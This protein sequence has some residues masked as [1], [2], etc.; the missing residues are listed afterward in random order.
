MPKLFVIWGCSGHAKVLTSI[1]NTQGGR[2]LAYFDNC[3]INS[4]N[5]EIPIYFGEAGF[6]TWINEQK[7]L[8][9]VKGL[10]AIGGR[11]GSD[12]VNI[13]NI[14]RSAGLNLEPLI[15]PTAFVCNTAKLGEGSQVLAQ[16]IVA[17]DS[18]LGDVCIINH[19]ASVDH[20]C[21]LGSGVHLAPGATI[22]GC[23]T[24]G[25]NVL[26]GAGAVIL[27]RLTIGSNSI[28]GAGAVVTKNVASGEVVMGNP[29]H[30]YVQRTGF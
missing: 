18:K 5:A 14:F 20:E 13:L 6:N 8:S 4:I 2:V 28:V 3:K 23:V 27:P 11:R 12:R 21:I 19:K 24:I 1:V 29:A 17:A 15:H 10:A 30:S 16:A 25:E 7:N 9:K 26:V 22:C